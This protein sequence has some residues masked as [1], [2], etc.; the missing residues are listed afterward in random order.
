MP[1]RRVRYF[2]F[3]TDGV[4]VAP[5]MSLDG[6]IIEENGSFVDAELFML[7]QNLAQRFRN[8]V[9]L[10]PARLPG[11]QERASVKAQLAPG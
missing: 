8:H 3:H 11:F 7:G 5:T 9:D 10:G 2:P 1:R 4:I 6:R